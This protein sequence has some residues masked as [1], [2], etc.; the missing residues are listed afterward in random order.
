MKIAC[1][2]KLEMD[3][4][5]GGEYDEEAVKDVTEDDGAR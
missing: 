4:I 3:K 1:R 2:L 5:G